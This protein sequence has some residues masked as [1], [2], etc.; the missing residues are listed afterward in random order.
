MSLIQIP[1]SLIQM[2]ISLIQIF[3]VSIHQLGTQNLASNSEFVTETGII[4]LTLPYIQLHNY[5]QTFYIPYACSHTSL[6]Y[7]L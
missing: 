7:L 6:T 1:M 5:L 4:Q 3:I 2:P